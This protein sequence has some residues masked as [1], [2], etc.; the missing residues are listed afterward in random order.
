[1]KGQ[2]YIISENMIDILKNLITIAI[3]LGLFLLFA[4]YNVKINETVEERM[5]FDAINSIIGNKCLI[6]GEDENFYRSIFDEKKLSEGN[7]CL[8][9][10]EFE[11]ELTD[12]ER[13]W[14]L[15]TSQ[16]KTSF[17][18]PITIYSGGKFKFGKMVVSH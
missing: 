7:I 15:G 9:L 13:T 16:H 14:K 18:L 12:F 2:A 8:N 1:M 11:V 3:L 17:T 5:V 10:N 6:Y 4:S